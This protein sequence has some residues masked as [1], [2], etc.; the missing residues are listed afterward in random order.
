VRFLAGLVAAAAGLYLVLLLLLFV[1]QRRFLFP[2]S[3]VRTSAAAAGLAGVEDVVIRTA[4]GQELV[5]WW[6][7]PRPGRAL[8]L[9]F[10]GNGGNLLNRR[11]RLRMLSQ[12]GRGVLLVSYRGYSG[13]TGSPSE[14]GLRL[15][16]RAA[17]G[18]LKTYAPERI[19]LYGE[20][21]GTGVAVKLATEVPVGGVVL[22]AP[23]TSTAAVAQTS[24]WFVPVSLLM[25][26]Q[27]RSIDRIG[28]LHRPLLVLHGEADGIIPIALS[29][30]LFAAANEPKRYV[31]L[32]GVDHVGVLEH[33]GVDHVRRFLDEVEAKL[34]RQV[35]A[36]QD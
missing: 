34:P 18:W 11:E 4:D 23:Y 33:G 19:V 20:S 35:G 30:A 25:R 3:S 12:D 2:A 32:P 16:A 10:H 9:Y 31:S 36:Q 15:D 14:A 1:Q 26:D 13:S 27:F 22:D 8:V 5:G 17:Y 24:F 6:K 21:L 28:R 7:A 29:R